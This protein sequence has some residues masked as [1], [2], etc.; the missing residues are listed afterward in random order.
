MSE[1][2]HHLDLLRRELVL[3]STLLPQVDR[4]VRDLWHALLYRKTFQK[5]TGSLN[6]PLMNSFFSLRRDYLTVTLHLTTLDIRAVTNETLNQRGRID[7]IQTVA[8]RGINHHHERGFFK[9]RNTTVAWQVVEA[10]IC[11][12]NT[13]LR[14]VEELL[15]WSSCHVLPTHGSFL[16]NA[17]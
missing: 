4:A 5:K 3:Y 15:V 1:V 2:P 12:T 11:R 10:T 13:L 6:C 14:F 16:L 9:H 7:V 17:V 8:V